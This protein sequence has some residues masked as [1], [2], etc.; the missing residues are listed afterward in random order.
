[1]VQVSLSSGI[2]SGVHDRGST[3]VKGLFGL[4]VD[5]ANGKLYGV[6][7][8]STEI[9]SFNDPLTTASVTDC[10]S[11][12]PTLGPA[13]GASESGGFVPEPATLVIWGIL[14]AVAIGAGWWRRRK[15]A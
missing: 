14:G 7:G 6:S 10:G 15:I 8:L 4:A 11:Y 5:D 9:Y 12:G 3:G 1:M 13:Y 2:V